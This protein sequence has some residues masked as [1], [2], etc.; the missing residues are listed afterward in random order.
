MLGLNNHGHKR[1][2]AAARE[3]FDATHP[4]EPVGWIEIVEEEPARF[5]VGVYYGQRRPKQ[6][7]LYAVDKETFAP[8]EIPDPR[9]SENGRLADDS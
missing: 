9:E 3:R 6:R 7:R 4:E 8:V 5:V 1:A 2:A